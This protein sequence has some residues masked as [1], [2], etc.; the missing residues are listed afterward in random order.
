[1]ITPI[2]QANPEYA[3]PIKA[4]LF[5]AVPHRG[6]GNADSL[7]GFLTA[8]KKVLLPGIGPNKK[9]VKD[10]ELKNKKLA[11]ITDRFIQLINGNS[12]QVISCYENKDYSPGKGK[13]GLILVFQFLVQEPD[14]SQ[15]VSKESATLDF[16]GRDQLPRPIDANHVNCA[17]FGSASQHP[18]VE[19]ANELTNIAHTAIKDLETRF[20]NLLLG[21]KQ[22]DYP[23][24]VGQSTLTNVIGPSLTVEPGERG[25]EPVFFQL[26]RYIT[27]FLVDDSTS[28]E[29][30]PDFN[31][32]SWSDTTHALTECAGLVLGARGRLKVHFFNS[33]KVK[34]N[35]SG[36]AELQ[37]LC[38][39]T[40]R[41]DTPTY[42]RLK[43]HLDEYIEA[44]K[45][46]SASQR[47]TFPGLNLVIFTDGAPE[48]PFEDIEEVI[49]D[50]AK[51][52]DDL[53]ADKYK[54]GIQFVQIGNDESVT[55][56]FERI[57]NEIKGEHGLRR[58]VRCSMTAL[59]YIHANILLPR[60]L[61]PP[62]T[63]VPQQTRAPIRR[64]CLAL[65]TRAR[66]ERHLQMPRMVPQM[67]SP[68]TI[69]VILGPR[70]RWGLL[71]RHNPA[72]QISV[73]AVPLRE[74]ILGNNCMSVRR[75]GFGSCLFG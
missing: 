1:M 31:I 7:S 61:T 8:L 72:T 27:V 28:M 12:I 69:K 60:L 57:D 16:A 39:F 15:I 6:T 48:G 46:L 58:D 75:L 24:G 62:V 73:L 19:I 3:T 35:I 17:R 4:C 25:I 55:N 42:Q 45:P 33:P 53:R 23:T 70:S 18:F 56:F 11:D 41:G 14:I 32:C 66:M 50:T 38:R 2:K 37:E 30:I 26:T 36:V 43:R 40:P 65:S 68:P 67:V 64:S 10:L 63:I 5:L 71:I 52:L 9:F 47:D 22:M 13:V 21:H 51:D 29:D 49:V 74:T 54:V 44:F 34:E 20:S 59:V